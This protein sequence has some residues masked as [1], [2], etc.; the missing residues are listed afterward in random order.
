L[1]SRKER[2]EIHAEVDSQFDADGRELKK[3]KTR[4]MQKRGPTSEDDLGSL[5]GDGMTGKLPRFANRITLKVLVSV[6]WLFVGVSKMYTML[7]SLIR[8][9]NTHYVS[10]QRNSS[11]QNSHGFGIN[12]LHY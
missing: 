4:K 8:N 10:S 3:K 11:I 7:V 12:F 1:L 6:L 9:P 5:F 2:E